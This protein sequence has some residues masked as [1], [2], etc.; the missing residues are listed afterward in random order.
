MRLFCVFNF[1]IF[2]P[3]SKEDLSKKFDSILVYST[4]FY[5]NLQPQRVDALSSSDTIL[6]ALVSPAAACVE[7][8]FNHQSQLVPLC[9]R[10][11]GRSSGQIAVLILS[12]ALPIFRNSEG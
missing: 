11:F 1:T 3:L 12:V 4:V 6:M 5:S 10:G 8:A 2:E 9:L 7:G